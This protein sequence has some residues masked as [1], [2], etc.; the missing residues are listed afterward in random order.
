M[1][2]NDTSD[3]DDH[4]S[5][6]RYIVSV[7]VALSTTLLLESMIVLIVICR[8]KAM[9]TN[10]NVMVAS[11]AVSNMIL[12]SAFVC[13]IDLELSDSVAN[14]P[15][16]NILSNIIK[17]VSGASTTLSI[18]HMGAIAIDR[19]IHIAHPFYYIKSMRKERII[20]VLIFIWV[21]GLVL[22]LVPVLSFND[23]SQ[24]SCTISVR[25]PIAYFCAVTALY[26]VNLLV[27]C[28]CYFKIA[29]LA[30]KHNKA[31]NSRRLRHDDS[32]FMFQRNMSAAMKS[33]KFF[34]AMF[35]VFLSFT[36][37]P[38]LVT[39][40]DYYYHFPENIL[41]PMN[42][43]LPVNSIMDFVIYMCM[44]KDFLQAFRQTAADIRLVCC[45][46]NRL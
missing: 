38:T 26:L 33:V 36:L 23:K 42:V 34:A 11:L 14:I 46:L 29:W 10:S 28:V 25:Q 37:P 22:L 13:T 3:F 8:T 43:L 41:F 2:I 45:K 35:G 40:L 5:L 4:D 24:E 44:N 17:G 7:V 18:M 21:I 31:A 12:G 1:A 15:K 9:H 19:Y 20:K 30:F 27:V 16:R 39:G 6:S 32:G